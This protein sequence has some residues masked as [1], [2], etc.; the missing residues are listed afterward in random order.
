MHAASVK[1]IEP[2]FLYT[3]HSPGCLLKSEFQRT[4]TKQ[5]SKIKTCSV[6]IGKQILF[7]LRFCLICTLNLFFVCNPCSDLSLQ[8]V[9]CVVILQHVLLQSSNNLARRMWHHALK[10]PR[11]HTH[12]VNVNGTQDTRQRTKYRSYITIKYIC[13]YPFTILSNSFVT[14]SGKTY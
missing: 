8:T 10:H 5:H 12:V 2:T 14:E 6:H 3:C 11:L 1:V 7:V 4:V 9:Q 13:R